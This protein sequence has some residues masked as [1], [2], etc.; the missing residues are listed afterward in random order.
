MGVR[1]D[2]LWLGNN[3]ENVKYSGNLLS[4]VFAATKWQTN[5]IT[6]SVALIW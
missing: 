2:Y 5:N 6:M 4:F 3:I 1:E